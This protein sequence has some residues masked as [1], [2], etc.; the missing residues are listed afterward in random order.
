M[1]NGVPFFGRVWFGS[2]PVRAGISPVMNATRLGPQLGE[3]TKVLEKFMPLAASFS[4][5]GVGMLASPC[6]LE[7]DME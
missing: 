4:I 5:Y 7:S 6:K 1:R 3:T 2:A